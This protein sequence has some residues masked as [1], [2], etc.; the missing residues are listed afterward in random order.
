VAAT[1]DAKN[2]APGGSVTALIVLANQGDKAALN[3]LFETLYGE[4]HSLAHSRLRRSAPM[5]VLD[6]TALVHESYLKL[7]KAGRLNVENRVHFLAYASRTMRSIIVDFARKRLA[8]R[9][10]SG[11]EALQLNT[12]VAETVPSGEEEIVRVHDALEALAQSE[13]RLAQVVEMRYYGGLSEHEIAEALGITD[14]TV[15]RDWQ[16]ARLLLSLSLA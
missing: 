8:E 10:G 9:R 14:R 3:A 6:T 15:R 16:K 7:L 2:A 11:A 4:L 12:D 5:T 13:L 1:G